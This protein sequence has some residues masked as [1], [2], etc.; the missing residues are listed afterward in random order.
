[1]HTATAPLSYVAPPMA[2]G[3]QGEKTNSLRERD[4][5]DTAAEANAKD[6]TDDSNKDAGNIEAPSPAMSTKDTLRFETTDRPSSQLDSDT[7]RKRKGLYL[8]EKNKK[9]RGSTSSFPYAYKN[10][11]Y[12]PK[13]EV[14][15]GGQRDNR[16]SPEKLHSPP[17]REKVGC[18]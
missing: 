9:R 5:A 16:V 1:M 8:H 4:P 7:L 17:L 10:N 13:E 2:C 12:Q 11:L 18:F 3:E 6:V 14:D 15:G